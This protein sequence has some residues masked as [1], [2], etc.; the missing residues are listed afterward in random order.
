MKIIEPYSYMKVPIKS[1]CEN[2]EEG[3]M[4]QAFNL[5][6]HPTIF[7]HVALM[8]DC[9]QGY[10]MP[11]GGVIACENAIIPNAVGVDIG[12]G[13]RSVK[14]NLTNISTD[15]IEE[16]IGLIR[17]NVPVGF[18][19]HKEPKENDLI[20]PSTF[21]Y[22]MKQEEK[23][24]DYQ[25]G[26]L[27]G[28]NHF[29]EIQK[30][31]DNFIWFMI[32]SG[33][34]NY[35]KKV[36]DYYNNIAKKL[37]SLWRSKAEDF[38]DLAFLPIGTSEAKSYVNE[39]NFALEFAKE[40][41]KQISNRVKESF[42]KI[43]NDVVFEND[44]DIHH[45]YAKL[46]NH[47]GRNVWIHRKGATSAKLDEIGIISGSMGSSSYIIQGLGNRDSFN[48]CSHGAGRKM[49]RNEAS[50]K[51]N[52]DDCNKA[53]EGIIY[54]NW[55]IDKKGNIDLGEAPQAYKD[56]DDVINA[57][58]DLVKVITRLKPLGVIKG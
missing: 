30:G 53:M 57:Q 11:I 14:T 51:L 42:F 50:R 3:A 5:S 18:N 6:C 2:L 16:I 23:N 9:H 1:W 37:N 19:H 44:L 45:N 26:T 29:I 7:Y 24:I 52:I 48:S 10:G 27:G 56:I 13:M 31:N 40:N 38:E 12:C 25:I 32:H 21:E 33:S 54:E 47:F 41:R 58:L 35:G 34:R 8:P 15:Q 22:I 4:H 46:E 20:M 39:M 28:G 36:C 55:K 49:G 43:I 17:K